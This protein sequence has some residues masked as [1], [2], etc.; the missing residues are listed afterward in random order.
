MSSDWGPWCNTCGGVRFKP[1]PL[2]FRWAATV[3]G[4]GGTFPIVYD[5]STSDYAY[6]HKTA[7]QPSDKKD[8]DGF[9]RPTRQVSH[10]TL[11][12]CI[13]VAYVD[14]KD[15][16]EDAELSVQPSP[17]TTEEELVVLAG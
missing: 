17:F 15:G 6:M 14:C 5:I 2:F 16:Q 7:N 11:D 4:P 10:G 12:A 1:G 3:Q 13:A 8:I 9:R